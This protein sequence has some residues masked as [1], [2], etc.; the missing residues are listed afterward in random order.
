MAKDI[1]LELCPVH[2]CAPWEFGPKI[3]LPD[4]SPF[5]KNGRMWLHDKWWVLSQIFPDALIFASQ[6]TVFCPEC[7]KKNPFPG[8]HNK[9]GYGFCSQY[10]LTAAKNNWNKAC[11]RWYV[12][13]V[14]DDLKAPFKKEKEDND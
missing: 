6:Y 7:A 8:K 11:M 13:K 12:S 3:D 9:F 2:G 10:S 4:I 5:E 14:K 1:K